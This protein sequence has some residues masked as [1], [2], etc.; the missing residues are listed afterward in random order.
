M[1]KQQGEEFNFHDPKFLEAKEKI[2]K[3]VKEITDK[4]IAEGKTPAEAM[5]VD[6]EFMESLYSQAYQ[7][8]QT[9]KYL[10]AGQ[11]FRTLLLL[12]ALEPKYAMGLAACFHLL[13]DYS[14]AIESYTY[15]GVIEPEN[16]FPYYYSS[17]CFLELQDKVSAIVCLEMVIKIAGDKPEHAQI[18]ERAKMSIAHL[19]S[20]L[21]HAPAKEKIEL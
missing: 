21:T 7:L 12:D 13:K 11:Q 6:P 18:K 5:E 3:G 17:D 1:T 20:E 8:Y 2:E 14:H 16:P 4:M 10:D 15:C 9:G 19:N